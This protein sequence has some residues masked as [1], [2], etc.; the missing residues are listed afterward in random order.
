MTE[1]RFVLD[2]N[3]AIYLLTSEHI[4]ETFAN[5]DFA[6]SIITRIELLVKWDISPDDEAELRSFMDDLEVRPIDEAVEAVVIA[7][8]RATHIKLPDCIV[9]ATAITSASVLLT[10]DDKLL[11]LVWPGYRVQDIPESL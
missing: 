8:R 4:P 6:M 2:T 7:L 9:A 1:N 11:R 3:A 5:A 10:H